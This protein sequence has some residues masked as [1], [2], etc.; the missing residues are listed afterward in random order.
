M[1]L[2]EL[3][4]GLLPFVVVGLVFYLTITCLDLYFQAHPLYVT[5]WQ[6]GRP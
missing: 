5:E 3:I 4:K 6:G 1:N 2:K